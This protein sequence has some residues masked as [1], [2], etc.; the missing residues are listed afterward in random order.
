MN[1]APFLRQSQRLAS[2]QIAK[3]ETMDRQLGSLHGEIS[4]CGLPGLWGW[5][6]MLE[7]EGTDPPQ[8]KS[9]PGPLL[10]RLWVDK[11]IDS[12]KHQNIQF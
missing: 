12:S 11:S 6:L 4:P 10:N 2:Q 9:A 8:K 5:F 1:T 3:A 7:K